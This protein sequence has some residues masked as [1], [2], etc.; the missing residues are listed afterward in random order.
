M[1]E[2]ET[3]LDRRLNRL[4]RVVTADVKLSRAQRKEIKREWKRQRE[5]GEASVY[6]GA[7]MVAA[8]IILAVMGVLNP[9]KFW[10]LF[11]ALGLG[12]GGVKQIET[13]RK[14]DRAP[15]KDALPAA[16]V[17]R[18]EI[19]CDQLLLE[20][21]D[22]PAAVRDFLGKPEATVEGIRAA[23]RQLKQRHDAMMQAGSAEDL[24]VE[25]RALEARLGSLDESTYR[26]ATDALRLRT[27]LFH[28]VRT[29]A[30]RLA[31]EQQILL[32]S[33][34]SLRMRVA[35]AKGAGGQGAS[36]TAMKGEVDRLSDELTAITDALEGV[37][38]SELQAVAPIEAPGEP[39]LPG[40]R[41]PIK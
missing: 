10:L 28:Q 40:Q 20:L 13:A 22:S 37:Q 21:K 32:A 9:S 8:A 23:C 1:A 39:P 30:E 41:Q 16:K 26:R 7:A 36:M 14:R 19:A 5:L 4:G 38:R 12:L 2:Q 6:A 3:E 15:G 35:L 34:E 33:L 25:R 29:S 11:V 18:F 31:S 17:E 24:E 27:E